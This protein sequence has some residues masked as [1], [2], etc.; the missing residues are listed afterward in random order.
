[1]DKKLK[2]KWIKALKSGKYRQGTG[3]LYT[4]E[5]RSYCCLGVLGKVA[6]KRLNNSKWGNVLSLV[7]D[8]EAVNALWKKNDGVDGQRQHT[9]AEIAALIEKNL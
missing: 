6:G 5:T 1:M 4:K 2:A 7:N 3:R 8:D 9:F